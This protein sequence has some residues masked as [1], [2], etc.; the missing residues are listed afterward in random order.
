MSGE[1]TT[2]TWCFK[3]RADIRR[4]VAGP[5]GTAICDECIGLAHE[6]LKKDGI[7][8]IEGVLALVA[9][10]ARLGKRVAELE[11]LLNTPEVIDFGKALRLEAAH[12][13]ERWGS[14][15]DAGKTD[16]D[17][18]WLLGYLASKA[19]HNPP[20]FD[21]PG[22]RAQQRDKKL[23]RIVTI[24]AAAANWHAQILGATNMRPGIAPPTG[25]SS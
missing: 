20:P 4:L 12:Q 14:D 13:R 19:L 8:A 11:N 1:P 15:H 18:L 6:A 3:A 9:D 21:A 5:T 24:A 10:N 25:E 16:A 22:H 2:C 7:D 17:W 23:H